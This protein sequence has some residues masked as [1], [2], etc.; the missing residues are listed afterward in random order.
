M[1]NALSTTWR[2]GERYVVPVKEK[3]VL[4]LRWMGRHLDILGTI[5]GSVNCKG[6][7]MTMTGSKAIV[8]KDVTFMGERLVLGGDA[9]IVGNLQAF[10]KVLEMSDCSV[11]SG[12][13]RD[14]CSFFG[15]SCFVEN[16]PKL[17][18][19]ICLSTKFR[20]EPGAQLD[21][22]DAAGNRGPSGAWDE[23]GD[24][25]SKRFPNSLWC[26]GC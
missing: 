24:K 15:E 2:M 20:L 17:A 7:T 11:G 23:Q 5:D 9:K 1:G 22:V 25:F 13:Q 19:F 18:S 3:Q 16:N 21:I 10:G 6:Q 4:N 12:S 8:T 26:E 14:V